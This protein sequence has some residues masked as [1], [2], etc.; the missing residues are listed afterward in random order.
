MVMSDK[1]DSTLG[2]KTLLHSALE[3]QIRSTLPFF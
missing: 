3:D 1:K 2:N